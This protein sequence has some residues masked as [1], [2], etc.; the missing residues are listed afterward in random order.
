MNNRLQLNGAVF[1]YDYDNYQVVDVYLDEDNDVVVNF[2]NV[3]QVKNYGAE[4]EAETLIGDSTLVNIAVSYLHARY[5]ATYLLHEDPFSPP[6]DLDGT[7]LP[8]APD[9]NIKGSI[10]HTFFLSGAGTLRPSASIRWSDAQYVAP[11]PGPNQTQDAYSIVDAYLRYGSPNGKLSL[12]L[13]AKNATDEVY[14]TGG[15]A[16]GMIVGEPRMIGATF[17]IKY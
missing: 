7:Q 12:T 5:D 8:H 17:Q 6:Y 9:W 15:V 11:W 4:I 10:E 14:K 2:F 16:H 13:W 3:E 1:W